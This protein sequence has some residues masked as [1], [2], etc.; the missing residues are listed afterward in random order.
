MTHKYE[1]SISADYVTNW[2]LY[3]AVREFVQ[4]SI[5][6]ERVNNNKSFIEYYGEEEVLIIGNAAGSLDMQSLLLGST[7]KRDDSRT[8][9]TH[10][11]GYKLAMLTLARMKDKSIQI[12]NQEKR[13]VWNPKLVKSRKYNGAEVLN[14]VVSDYKSIPTDLV[15]KKDSSK[16]IAEFINDEC[17]GVVVKI[18]GISKEEYEDE[19]YHKLMCLRRHLVNYIKERSSV[20]N[21]YCLIDPEESGNIYV[22]GLYI[23]HN[24]SIS[25]GY[26]FDPTR[27][28]LD[29]DRKLISQ[30]DIEYESACIWRDCQ[31]V[32]LLNKY[33]YEAK[34]SQYL[35]TP[36]HVSQNQLIKSFTDKYGENTY[37]VVTQDESDKIRQLYGNKITPVITS[38]AVCNLL[39]S[40]LDEM[41]KDMEDDNPEYDHHSV[42][43]LMRYLN[44]IVN[45]PISTMR[46]NTFLINMKDQLREFIDGIEDKQ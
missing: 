29:R 19:I 31:D 9:G 20:I 10:G 18:T 11:E 34:E 44:N 37:P 1:L 22:G 35:G 13:Q 2:S 36:Y 4:N 15:V 3:E 43:D 12:F 40:D 28:T 27:V 16:G 32:E 17:K 25:Y 39:K 33:I 7:T 42:S 21:N 24:D 46:D 8:I 26:D 14:V 45:T 23:C 38:R 6:E 30:F 41:Y 5:D